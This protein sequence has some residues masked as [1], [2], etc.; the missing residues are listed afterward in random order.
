MQTGSS[1]CFKRAT[2]PSRVDQGKPTGFSTSKRRG[3]VSDWV[4]SRAK[5]NL[6]AIEIAGGMSRQCASVVDELRKIEATR[7]P[8]SHDSF[9]GLCVV[10]ATHGGSW[11]FSGCDGFSEEGVEGRE[12]RL[13]GQPGGYCDE[14][15][16]STAFSLLLHCMF[17]AFPLPFQCYSIVCSLT[18]HCLCT[19]GHPRHDDKAAEATFNIPWYNPLC[20][21]WHCCLAVVRL[22]HFVFPVELGQDVPF[23]FNVWRFLAVTT[24]RTR[25]YARNHG[26]IVSICSGRTE[27]HSPP[28]IIAY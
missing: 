28:L 17:A 4:L 9:C 16:V 24:V 18:F 2:A 21:P 15:M 8:I 13:T 14:E 12:R 5:H 20:I 11:V 27:I 6:R 1:V 22:V 23:V 25:P 19:A 7:P 10:V 26:S 3:V